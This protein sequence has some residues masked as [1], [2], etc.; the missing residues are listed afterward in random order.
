MAPSSSW[1]VISTTVRRK[2]GST[3]DGDE[4]RSLP[5][6]DSTADGCYPALER[7]DPGERAP[8]PRSCTRVSRS[9]RTRRRAP[10][11]SPGRAS[12]APRRARA[13]RGGSRART[14]RSRPRRAGRSPRR[15]RASGA[16]RAAT[17]AAPAASDEQEPERADARADE[18]RERAPLAAAEA[19]EVGEE[20]ERDGR[21]DGERDRPA[22]G[23]PRSRGAPRSRR[24]RPR[25]SRAR[26]RRP[27]APTAARRR[28]R[29]AERDDR[30]AGDDRRDDAHRPERQRLVERRE[31]G[32]AADAGQDPDPERAPV[33]PAA[34]RPRARRAAP[35]NPAACEITVT[36][37]VGSRRE[38]SPP[39]KSAVPHVAD[40]S[41]REQDGGS[42]HRV[43]LARVPFA[44]MEPL[45]IGVLAV[46]GNFREHAA[47]LRRL[48]AEVVEVRKPE[49]LDR[50][51][52]PRHPGR[53]VDHVHAPDATSTGSTRRSATSAGPVFGTCAGMIVLDRDH[54][55]LVDIGVRRN[56]FGR[57]VAS[58]ETDLELPGRRRAA[59]RRVHPRAVDRG[60]RARRRGARRGRRPSGARARGPLP[61]RR[62][63]SGADRRHAAPRS[64]SSNSVQ[65]ARLVRA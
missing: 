57:Q 16:R 1:W 6:S 32:S 9:W 14:A 37:I 12:R 64:C 11:S 60:G 15:E 39:E 30:A 48:G 33:D 21:D 50:P 19:E 10:S 44:A 23:S 17:R 18:R 36:G 61:R 42:T 22:R 63:P 13:G 59:A 24:A 38:T 34:V 53:R 62:V 56:A 7:R 47:M 2:F 4:I 41:E 54:L 3:S 5:A 45:R 58:F 43:G 31:P 49:Q 40:E 26:R 27:R 65:E 55:G 52:R 28:D 25:R 35:T 46:Q 29:D 8:R 51:R 20:A